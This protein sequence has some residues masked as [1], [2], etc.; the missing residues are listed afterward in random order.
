MM[1]LV[2]TLRIVKK[3]NIDIFTTYFRVTLTAL[4][5]TGTMANF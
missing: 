3:L 1:T 5:V 4:D 2:C